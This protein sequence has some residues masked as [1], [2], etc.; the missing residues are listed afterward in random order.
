MTD[1]KLRS[2]RLKALVF[3]LIRACSYFFLSSY[4]PV[5]C[6]SSSL[7]RKLIAQGKLDVKFKRP[8]VKATKKCPVLS[9]VKIS[10]FVFHLNSLS[11]A[12]MMNRRKSK[13]SDKRENN[14]FSIPG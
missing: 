4:F 14:C 6:T 3:L 2:K 1:I 8:D 13:K 9:N 12:V 10:G 11:V 7:L 5:F